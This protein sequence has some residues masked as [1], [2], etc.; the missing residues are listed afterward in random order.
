MVA[1]Y[2]ILLAGGSG[3]RLWP[4]SREMFP[5][6]MFKLDDEYTLFQKTFLNLS[7]FVDDKNI[8]TSTN[9]KY[10]SQIKEQLKKLQE[11]YCR[12]YDYKVVTEPIFKNTAPAIVLATKY[13]I[14]NVHYSKTEPVI[15][16]VPSDQLFVQ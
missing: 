14:D 7:N 12:T 1:L 15:I 6:Q 11:T 8:I 5:K 10:A 3:S 4:M 9:I 13:I 16:A 2:S